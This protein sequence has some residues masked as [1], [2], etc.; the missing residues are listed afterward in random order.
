MPAPPGP[1]HFCGFHCSALLWTALVM[2]GCL[3]D[4]VESWTHTDA[5]RGTSRLSVCTSY[6]SGALYCCWKTLSV[7]S[8]EEWEQVTEA[9]LESR[10][11]LLWA[12]SRRDTCSSHQP[13]VAQKLLW[14][15]LGSEATDSA[16]LRWGQTIHYMP[17][18]LH[19]NHH[20]GNTAM[21]SEIIF[22]HC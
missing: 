4:S 10:P 9:S 18:I 13:L 15:C 2:K 20:H 5:T 21:S 8:L 22:F 12:G 7:S 19:S 14:P 17:L 1:A 16:S 6:K 3:G 11:A